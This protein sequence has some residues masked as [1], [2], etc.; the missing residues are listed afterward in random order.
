MKDLIVRLAEYGLTEKESL[1]YLAMLELGPA[2]VQDIAKKSGVNRAT[3]YVMIEALKRRGLMSTFDKGRKT[4]FVAESPERLK[5]LS[6]VEMKAAEE[7]A[8]RLKQSLPLFMALFNSATLTKP[9]VRFFEGDEGVATCR[10]LLAQ[11]Q[12]EIL[13]FGALDEGTLALSKIDEMERISLTSRVHGRIVT[14]MKPGVPMTKLD[15]R[16]WQVRTIP[17]EQF[18]FTGDMVF[19]E[20]KI[21]IFFMKE[22]PEVFLLESKEMFNLLKTMFELSWLQAK[23]LD[24][25]ETAPNGRVQ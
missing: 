22:K 24:E 20:G 8:D 15:L 17:I 1:V 21:F 2:S 19:C 25:K 6:D 10:A 11:T 9:V 23:P 7:K 3:T 4:M 13:N 16:M 18:T 12:D 14:A 5:H